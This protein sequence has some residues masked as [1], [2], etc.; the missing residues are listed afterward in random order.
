MTYKSKEKIIENL[1]LICY[2]SSGE[3]LKQE[4]NKEDNK[5]KNGI[6]TFSM[7]LIIGIII[8]VLL[9]AILDNSD[10]KMTYSD[11]ITNIESGAVTSIIIESDGSKAYVELKGQTISKEVNIP[12]IQSFMDYANEGLK[13]GSFTL[14]EKSQSPLITILSILSPFGIVAIL[15]IFGLMLM[16]TGNNNGNKTMSFGKSK[17]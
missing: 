15:L 7:W 2:I 14:E 11:L 4:E 12:N 1:I 16:N 13:T 8:I 17:A 9:T 3:R 10:K 5:V 6:K